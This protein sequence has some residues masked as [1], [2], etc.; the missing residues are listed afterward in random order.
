MFEAG[1]LNL[2][3]FVLGL[4]AWILPVINLERRNKVGNR[5]WVGVSLA[6]V[7]ACAISLC[8]QMFYTNYL[9]K[10]EDWSALMD[11]S[12]AVAWVATMLLAVTIILNAI[13]LIVYYKENSKDR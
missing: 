1:W 12:A 8:M 13:T 2:G 4:I 9:V 3:S 11:T 6:S 7:S 5:N 10:I